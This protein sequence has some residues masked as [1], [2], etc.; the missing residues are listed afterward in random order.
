MTTSPDGGRTGKAGAASMF[1]AASGASALGYA[2]SKSGDKCRSV[3]TIS[4]DGVPGYGESARNANRPDFGPLR[5]VTRQQ[6]A[7][8]TSTMDG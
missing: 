6:P 8:G 7:L 5:T 3:M 2:P 4:L 1:G